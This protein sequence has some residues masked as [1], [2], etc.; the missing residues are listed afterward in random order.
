MPQMMQVTGPMPGYPMAPPMAPMYST[1]PNP[2]FPYMQSAPQP[3]MLPNLGNIRKMIRRA[4][5]YSTHHV[6]LI[7]GVEPKLETGQVPLPPIKTEDDANKLSNNNILPSLSSLDI[8]RSLL[9]PKKEVPVSPMK[10]REEN[11]SLTNDATNNVNTNE[12]KNDWAVKTSQATG[13][14]VRNRNVN[15]IKLK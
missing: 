9:S 7:A 3:T 13:N 14:F 11:P 15:T 5:R 10:P 4:A 1:A 6:A 2:A 8:D 12:A